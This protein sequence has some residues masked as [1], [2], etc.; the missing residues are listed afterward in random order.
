VNF[1][2][3]HIYS[4]LFRCPWPE[5]AEGQAE[6]EFEFRGKHVFRQRFG[7]VVDQPVYAWIIDGVNA[8]HV[9]AQL[10]RRAI[11]Q[12]NGAPSLA[13][14]GYLYHFTSA[15]GLQG[16]LASGELW[17]TDYRD[18]KD[19]AEI[20]DGLAVAKAILD[21][22]SPDVHNH[23][24]EILRRLVGSPLAGEVYVACFCMLKDAPYHW[25]E[26]AAE[27]SG[28]ALVIDP[29]GFEPLIASDPFAIQFSRVAYVWDVKAGLFAHLAVWFDELIRFDVAR[30]VFDA[31]AC[32]REMAQIFSE[33][34][35]MCKD[36]S[37]FREHEVRLVVSPACSKFGLASRL[38][39]RRQNGRRYVT[40]RDVLGDFNLPIERVLLGPM[41][42]ED[43]RS[44]NVETSKLEQLRA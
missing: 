42:A 14:D 38:Y 34:L 44:L 37:F 11:A 31:E 5:C 15:A 1:C 12:V 16:I 36:V 40:T 8:A 10:T 27:S 35:P 18:F 20:R 13:E 43:I 29:L 30:K 26:H 6:A 3:T 41:F 23:T 21:T 39:A 4:G 7:D 22:F 32:Q 28:A 25:S 2:W 17:L 24:R 33:L 19:D 9:A